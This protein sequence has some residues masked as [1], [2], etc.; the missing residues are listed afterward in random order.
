MDGF[1]SQ[2]FP[3]EEINRMLHAGMKVLIFRPEFIL[4]CHDVTGYAECIEKLLLSTLK[5]RIP[6]ELLSTIKIIRKVVAKFR[7][8]CGYPRP[9]IASD[10]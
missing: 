6:V 5:S 7:L 1:G 2:D 10:T 3:V 9:I 4:Q 8:C